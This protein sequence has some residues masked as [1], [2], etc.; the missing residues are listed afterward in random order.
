MA[1]GWRWGLWE[2]IVFTEGQK[3]WLAPVLVVELGGLWVWLWRRSRSSFSTFARSGP[4]TAFIAALLPSMVVG[5][6]VYALV[7]GGFTEPPELSLLGLQL[8][9]ISS[10]AAR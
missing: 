8:A 1:G 3:V 5:L 6:G 7:V 2:A 10:G 9:C 4:V